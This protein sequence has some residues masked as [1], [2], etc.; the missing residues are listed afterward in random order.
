MG[1]ALA[2]LAPALAIGS[3]TIAINLVVD[4]LSAHEGG[5]LAD[6]MV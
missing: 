1:G 5:S 2:S 3:L 4:D 6:R